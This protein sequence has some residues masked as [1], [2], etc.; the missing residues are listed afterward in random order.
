MNSGDELLSRRK[1]AELLGIH[2]VTLRKWAQHR[3]N[4]P[5]VM[6][7]GTNGRRGVAR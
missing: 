6:I 2:I 7:G 4:L 5:F 1:V 3:K